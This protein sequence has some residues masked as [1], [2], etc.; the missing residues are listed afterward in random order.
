MVH[1]SFVLHAVIC[2]PRD[3]RSK[4]DN[5]LAWLLCL[6]PIQ[7]SRGSRQM[8]DSSVSSTGACL[9][10]A[11]RY[12]IRG[13]LFDPH[14]CHC[15]ACQKASGAPVIAGAFLARDALKII[16][17]EPKFYQSSTIVERGFCADCGTYLIYRPLIPEWSD[18]IVITIASLDHPEATPPK[19]HYGT[20]S[21][22]P[23][24]DTQDDFPRERYE[25]DFIEIL[26]DPDH[27]E[28]T[29]VLER[30]GSE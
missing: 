5:R 19:R 9:C 21:Q 30:Y 13:S 14:Y 18:W 12:E 23:W 4:A 7:L 25:E 22:L 27:L 17:G 2:C 28:R 11:V 8:I 10:G 16:H 24:F 26:S 1:Q 20:E 3:S 6:Y 29:A 15:R